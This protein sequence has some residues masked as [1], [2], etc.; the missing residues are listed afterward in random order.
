MSAGIESQKGAKE[1]MCGGG[2]ARVEDTGEPGRW[3]RERLRP[4]LA[5][6]RRRSGAEGGT[7]AES[8]PAVAEAI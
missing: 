6:V 1:R 7:F 3:S 5:A 2:A 4:G 8:V